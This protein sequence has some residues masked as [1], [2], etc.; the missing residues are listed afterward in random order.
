[1]WLN[2]RQGTYYGQCTELCGVGHAQM[3][4]TVVSLPQNQ[5]QSCVF[6]SPS[7]IVDSASSACKPSGG[8]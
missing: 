2:A 1:M 5:Y 8:S 7:G 3:L 6:G 4:I